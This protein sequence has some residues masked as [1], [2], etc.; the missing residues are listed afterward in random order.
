MLNR[1]LVPHF[2]SDQC[3]KQWCAATE[4]AAVPVNAQITYHRTQ[5]GR[6]ACGTLALEATQP[7]EPMLRQPLTNINKALCAVLGIGFT[8]SDDLKNNGR[9]YLQKSRPTPIRVGSV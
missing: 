7:T 6:E 9:E 4:F 2:A 3:G 1:F 8:H 5:P